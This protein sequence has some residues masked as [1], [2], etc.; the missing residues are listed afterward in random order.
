MGT[1]IE[2]KKGRIVL[3]VLIFL[4]LTVLDQAAKAWALANIAG[5]PS[6]DLI[7]GFVGLTYVENSGMAF[8]MLQGGRL[9]F[10][11][12]YL[13]SM[14]VLLVLYIRSPLFSGNPLLWKAG[15]VLTAAGASGNAFDRFVR[16]YVIDFI[17]FRFI[18]FPV[19]NLADCF[20]VCGC[21]G[22]CLLGMT[23]GG[24]EAGR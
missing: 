22:L 16:S 9:F 21:L 7:P 12:V 19:F 3:P 20:V 5:Q 2:E 24:K 23:D 18:D 14:V 15:I 17:A 8:G 1:S 6:R 4:L 10:L 11:L 13:V